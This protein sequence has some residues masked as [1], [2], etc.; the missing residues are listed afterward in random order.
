M[1]RPVS[2]DR[3][4]RPAWRNSPLRRRVLVL[5]QWLVQQLGL[6]GKILV[7][8]I[9]V[10]AAALAA[11]T[12][13]WT[14]QAN[15][16]LADIMGEQARQI[17]YTLSLA[18]QPEIASGNVD[19]LGSM[20]RDLLKTHNIVFVVF[21]DWR[22]KCLSISHRDRTAELARPSLTPADLESL[23]EVHPGTSNLF[24]EFMQVTSPVLM[25]TLDEHG[26]SVSRLIGYV[27]V[28]V[29]PAREIGQLR[30]ANLFAVGIG[31]IVLLLG[32]PLGYLL[33]HRIFMPI[34]QLVDATDRIAAGD[35]EASVAI[36]RHDTIGDLARAFNKMINTVKRQREDLQDANDE[37]EEKVAYRTAQLGTANKR[38]SDEIAEKEDFLRAVS[39]DLN[40]PLRNISGMA[41]MLLMKHRQTFDEDVIHRLE[42]IQKNV[43]AETDLISEL[44]ELSRIKTR[45]QKM[46]MVEIAPLVR[47]LEGMFENDLKS[48]DI[49]L[50]LDTPL[51][52]INGERPRLRQIFQ[53]LIDNAIKYMGDG[54]VRE[55]HIGCEVKTH[56]AE[57][58]VRDTGLGIDPEDLGKIFFVFRRGKGSTT[59]NVAGK[60]VG[61]ASVK[62]IIETYS[63][64]IWAES[65]PGQGSTFRFTLNG[66]YVPSSQQSAV[67]PA[68]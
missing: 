28:G 41:A 19:Q 42:R 33:V 60:G 61:L 45:R 56:E 32:V 55:I 17:A 35:L 46:E 40:A 67:K 36:D 9:A 29:S 1:S 54:P 34:R 59:R 30:R 50:I 21:Y 27:S 44:L 43:E 14:T 3:R 16:R 47:E 24:G 18:A 20:G 66:Q 38:L 2:H 22:G 5:R 62:S 68:T 15:N 58:H 7:A 23:T 10:L 6:E 8:L 26:T 39:H 11:T 63:G 12:G 51:P 52:V 65:Q 48:R 13:A 4:Q 64:K 53:N 37:L 49:S 57:F 25:P 31:G